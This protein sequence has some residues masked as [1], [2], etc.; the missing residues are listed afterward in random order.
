M[1]FST[2]VLITLGIGNNAICRV[3]NSFKRSCTLFVVLSRNLCVLVFLGLSGRV[4]CSILK[5][6]KFSSLVVTRP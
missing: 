5:R 2:F 3:G 6:L 4:H 1:F